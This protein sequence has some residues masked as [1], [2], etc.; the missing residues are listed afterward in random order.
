MLLKLYQT[1]QPILRQ[2]AKR[3]TKQQLASKHM[4]DVID[5]MVDTLRDAPG[6]GLA[7]P[8]VGESL[9]IIIIDDKAEYHEAVPPELLKEQRREPV[10]LKVLV[11]P[12]LEV[13]D[14]ETALYFEG[15][16]S[17]DGYTGAVARYKSVKVTGWDRDGNDVALTAQ[18]WFARIL[19][20]E[21]D[22]LLGKLYIDV[23]LPD[24]FCS[25]KN[26]QL[27]YRKSLEADLR[28]TFGQR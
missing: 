28:A 23:M 20:H 9:Q 10:P 26:F 8:Q 13:V 16:L 5:F 22:H 1:G 19:Q 12:T 27:L 3:V 18:G 25:V 2:P 24:S 7:A 6:V 21:C 14:P 15:C 17:V 11:N 4:Q